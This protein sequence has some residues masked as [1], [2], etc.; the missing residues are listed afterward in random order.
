MVRRARDRRRR[1]AP[2]PVRRR[3]RLRPSARSDG[4]APD[5]AARLRAARARRALRAHRALHRNGNGLRD[6]L[7]ERQGRHRLQ[8]Q[9]AGRCRARDDRQRR[10]LPQADDARPVGVRVGGAGA[11]ASSS[12]ATD[13]RRCSRG[14]RS[15]FCV[16]ADIDE[17]TRLDSAAQALEGT[18]AGHDAVR[19]HPRACRSRPS[20]R[21][22]AR[23]RRRPRARAPLHR[24]HA[25]RERPPH[26]LPRGRALDHP[27]VG[28]HAAPAA[29]DR[30]GG[31]G[32]GDRR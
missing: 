17:F 7:G 6:P 14:S 12:R 24:A 23:A 30:A 22:T 18:R 29:A 3:D 26:R 32:E 19:P 5:R 20:P 1:S 21:S 16:G 13:A 9:P 8:A 11:R 15:V 28:R 31:G 25:R 2:E 10:G 27:R 4:R